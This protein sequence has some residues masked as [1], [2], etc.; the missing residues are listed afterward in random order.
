MLPA[1]IHLLFHLKLFL[2][3]SKIATYYFFLFNCLPKFLTF[4]SMPNISYF[5]TLLYQRLSNSTRFQK[6]LQTQKSTLYLLKQ[7]FQNNSFRNDALFS[8]WFLSANLNAMLSIWWYEME[9]DGLSLNTKKS[10]HHLF[11]NK[12]YL[13]IIAIS[14]N[15]KSLHD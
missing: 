4:S 5:Y 6:P 1:T 14:I 10:L 9:K 8:K 12:K 11:G 3:L 15:P 2:F 13:P 7:T